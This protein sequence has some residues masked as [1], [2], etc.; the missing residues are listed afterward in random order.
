[1]HVVRASDTHLEHPAAPDRYVAGGADIVDALRGR[2]PANSPRLDVDHPRRAYLDRFS[3]VVTRVDRLVEA[4]RR[5]DL[6]LQRGVVDEVIVCEG[7]LDHRRLRRI[8]PLEQGDVLEGVGGVRI[9]H[10]GKVGEVLPRR[11]RYLDLESRFD[12]QLDPLIAALELAPDRVHQSIDRRLDTDGDAA[13]DPVACPAE[14][15]GERLVRA[16]GKEV[17]HR[18]LDRRLRHAVLADPGE[19]PFDVVGRCEVGLQELRQDELFE[20]VQDRPRGLARIPGNLP[21]DALAPSDRAFRLDAA[22]HAGHVRL[23][24]ST[25]LVRVLE[26][27]AHDEELDTLELH[28][29]SSVSRVRSRRGCGTRRYAPRP[30]AVRRNSTAAYPSPNARSNAP[31]PASRHSSASFPS[32]AFSSWPARGI[33]ST[34]CGPLTASP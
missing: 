25:R 33:S 21:G 18:H 23:A 2:E 10:E 20:R 15:R 27:K 22:E 31:R 28:T 26:R 11:F 12:L 4:D 16:L 30:S 14:E 5:R 6:T 1:M 24:R 17:P 29:S 7:L 3:G 19:P 8:D 32:R 13:K 34:T 9:E